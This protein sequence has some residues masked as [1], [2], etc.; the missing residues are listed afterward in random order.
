ML[1]WDRNAKLFVDELS[2]EKFILEFL[3]CWFKVL[4]SSGKCSCPLL[5]KE[6]L[7]T[8]VQIE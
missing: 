8:K 6:T 1:F 3:C 5:E 4:L 7:G 2:P